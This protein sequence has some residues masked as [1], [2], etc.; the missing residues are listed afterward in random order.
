MQKSNLTTDNS[1]NSYVIT[2]KILCNEFI[3]T[4]VKKTAQAAVN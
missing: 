3:I 2:S 1:L 4:L